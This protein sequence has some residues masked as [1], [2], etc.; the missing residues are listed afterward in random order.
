MKS[1]KNSNSGRAGVA[2]DA[3]VRAVSSELECPSKVWHSVVLKKRSHAERNDQTE[4]IRSLLHAMNAAI[5]IGDWK[6]DGRCDPTMLM[7]GAKEHLLKF[8]YTHDELT[9]TQCVYESL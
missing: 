1:K 3:L 4:W 2:V 5:E 7:E 9:E 6:V 8:G